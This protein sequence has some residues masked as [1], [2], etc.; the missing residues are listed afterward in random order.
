MDE[1]HEVAGMKR[2]LSPGPSAS[3]PKRVKVESSCEDSRFVE[4][5]NEVGF[6]ENDGWGLR[7][8]QNNETKTSFNIDNL[9]QSFGHASED[10]DV[11]Y[12]TTYLNAQ[13]KIQ[14]VQEATKNNSHSAQQSMHPRRLEQSSPCPDT[15][16]WSPESL[17]RL[18][19][20]SP[21]RGRH[22]RPPPRL[23]K[24]RRRSTPPPPPP[25][26]P[27]APRMELLSSPLGATP[28]PLLYSSPRS[29]HLVDIEAVHQQDI[30]NILSLGENEFAYLN[31][32]VPPPS[33]DVFNTV[34]SHRYSLSRIIKKK[35]DD[36]SISMPVD[37]PAR[38]PISKWTVVAR[39]EQEELIGYPCNDF[40]FRTEKHDVLG[41][42][43]DMGNIKDIDGNV[44]R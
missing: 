7:T 43:D 11:K 41:S 26:P 34:P 20:S 23:C 3:L 6:Q 2:P 17:T 5:D 25:L 24:G 13:Y 28:P 19:S 14:Q 27:S 30:R 44:V 40:K 12:D 8:W 21:C 9:S 10:E 32:I 1:Q 18:A 15:R 36:E 4:Q 38:G 37:N 22:S 16:P 42:W 33:D 29:S 31:N 39:K 35:C